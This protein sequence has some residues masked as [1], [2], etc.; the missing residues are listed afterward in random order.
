MR[1]YIK[2]EGERVKG[3]LTAGRGDGDKERSEG[4]RKERRR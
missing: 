1:E 3:I 2:K 4:K